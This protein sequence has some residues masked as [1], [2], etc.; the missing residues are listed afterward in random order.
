MIISY[1]PWRL[2]VVLLPQE[3]QQVHLPLNLLHLPHLMQME[4]VVLEV[5]V[6]LHQKVGVLVVGGV[7]LQQREGGRVEEVE[8][9]E[10]VGLRGQEEEQEEPS[11]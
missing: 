10:L 6:H 3:Q 9:G 7:H 1:I 11:L 4:G 5:G 8:Q 2:C